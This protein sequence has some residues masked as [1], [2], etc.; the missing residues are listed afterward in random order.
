MRMRLK[1]VAKA[2]LCFASFAFLLFTTMPAQGITV[3]VPGTSDPWLAGMPN[4]SSAS[5]NLGSGE[6]ADFAPAE[7]PVLVGIP[8]LTGTALRWSAGGLVG[9]PG[10][11][12]DPD[13]KTALINTTHF[14][15]A[16]NGISNI[17]VPIDSLLGVFLGPS[18]PNLNPAPGALDFSSPASRD[19]LVLNPTL[20]QVFFMGD[21]LTDGAAVQ[22]IIAPSGATRLYLGTMD[23]FSWNNNI[24]SFDVTV[25]AV[26]EPA[27]MLLLGSGL[28]GL[29]GYAR[30]KF[31]K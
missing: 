26:P 28:L 13:G 5:F 19:Y 25:N 1:I 20:Q 16:E 2:S 14:T 11:I 30:K 8:I 6:P 18:Q 23:G 24:G 22:T 12:T 10:D 15:G 17:T 21:G 27:T 29:A 4:G 3:N 9:H 31:K 7:S